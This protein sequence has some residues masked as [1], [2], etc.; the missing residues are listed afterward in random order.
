M[1]PTPVSPDL[2]ADQGRS[3]AP[4][5]EGHTQVFKWGDTEVIGVCCTIL[6]SFICLR[7]YLL[8]RE[9]EKKALENIIFMISLLLP[10][11]EMGCV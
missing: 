8:L 10:P 5:W 4:L 2:Q 9:K 7:C 6:S 3:R 11:L 1:P